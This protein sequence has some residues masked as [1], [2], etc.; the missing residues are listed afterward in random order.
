[1]VP[2]LQ[3]RRR[4]GGGERAIVTA[5]WKAESGQ[6]WT[7]P[8]GLQVSKVTRFGS[9]PVNL[10]LGYYWNSKHPDGAADRQVRFQV[11]FMFPTKGR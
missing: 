4:L 11:N 9:Q 2:Q 7:I 6:R 1:M 3:L 5:D 10:L 8:W